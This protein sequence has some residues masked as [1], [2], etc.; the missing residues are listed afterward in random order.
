MR[1][2]IG[3]LPGGGTRPS[4]IA[5]RFGYFARPLRVPAA[6]PESEDYIRTILI[7]TILAGR[8]DVG[9]E[10]SAAPAAAVA[11]AL[12][13]NRVLREHI[14]KGKLLRGH[15][16]RE[17]LPADVVGSIRFDR[18]RF[19]RPRK[20]RSSDLLSPHR[21]RPFST[22]GFRWQILDHPS[23]V[24]LKFEKM[25]GASKPGLCHAKTFESSYLIATRSQCGSDV[26]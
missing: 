15:L 11:L 21:I 6:I 14:A 26:I 3:L 12:Q 8:A 16:V 7:R 10:S 19:F 4:A 24:D 18:K 23:K 20:D 17:D 13:R 5:I 25:L 1:T 2:K 22:T 9:S